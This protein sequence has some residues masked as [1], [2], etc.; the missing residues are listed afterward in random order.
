VGPG[1]PGEELQGLRRG[2]QQSWEA[3]SGEEPDQ[4]GCE[5]R[6]VFEEVEAR[7]RSRK[8]RVGCM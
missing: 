1:Q 4:L 6:E 3:M 7:C 5:L 8:M 2:M